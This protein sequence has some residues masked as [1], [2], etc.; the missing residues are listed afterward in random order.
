MKLLT[1]P[2]IQWP[3]ELNTLQL[4]K[5]DANKQNTEEENIFTTLTVHKQLLE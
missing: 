5:I 2:H 3:G 1:D 4:K